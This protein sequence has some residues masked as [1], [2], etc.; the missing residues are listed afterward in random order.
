MNTLHTHT[1]THPSLLL[2]LL[3]GTLLFGFMGPAAQAA[4]S[5]EQAALQLI[6]QSS[7]NVVEALQSEALR[8]SLPLVKTLV[9][10]EVAPHIDTQIM[11]RWALG[12]HWRAAN[13]EQ[14]KEIESL[15]RQLLIQTYAVGLMQFTGEEVIVLNARKDK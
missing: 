4:D 6:A 14:R 5:D 3:L 2:L 13:E 7:Q 11:T 8:G 9:E 12:K 10:R 1:T 15:F